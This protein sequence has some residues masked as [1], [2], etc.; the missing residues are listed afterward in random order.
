MLRLWQGVVVQPPAPAHYSKVTYIVFEPKGRWF[1]TGSWDGTIQLWDTKTGKHKRTLPGRL[2][3]IGMLAISPDGK[4]VA[5]SP[6]ILGSPR[7]VNV[8]SVRT[9][10]LKT[11]L[12]HDAFIQINDIAFG[13]DSRHL[14]AVGQLSVKG[15]P[16]SGSNDWAL[17]VYDVSTGALSGSV[18]ATIWDRIFPR[19]GSKTAW[20]TFNKG[21]LRKLELPSLKVLRTMKFRGR[22][23][24]FLSYCRG[25]S[26]VVAIGKTAQVRDLS[27]GAWRTL[28]RLKSYP[29]YTGGIAVSRCG[30]FAVMSNGDCDGEIPCDP[31][32][33]ELKLFRPPGKAPNVTNLQGHTTSIGAFAFSPDGSTLVAGTEAGSVLRWSTATGKRIGHARALAAVTNIAFSADNRLLAVADAIGRV[34]VHDL[35]RGTQL[36]N[37][38]AGSPMIHSLEFVADGRQLVVDTPKKQV[39]DLHPLRKAKS[40]GASP[41]A[42]PGRYDYTVT[43]HNRKGTVTVG[44]RGKT[45]THQAQVGHLS[46]VAHNRVS[47]LVAAGGGGLEWGGIGPFRNIPVWHIDTGKRLRV[48]KSHDRP[49][50]LLE[51]SR[52]GRFLASASEEGVVKVW[53]VR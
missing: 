19:P 26:M 31:S 1:A 48:L 11:T 50:S 17:R 7:D 14:L 24:R 34:R 10:T 23:I 44:I 20:V 39:W 28:V 47:R 33:L 30:R 51:F 18:S 21:T 36:A 32:D 42:V 43:M 12:Q 29:A 27:K 45:T 15:D 13:A 53:R 52:D 8:W 49:I 22:E 3:S 16:S 37:F 2:H 40:R 6:G 38:V 4:Y 25:R 9:G 41:P 46:A 35:V 5:S